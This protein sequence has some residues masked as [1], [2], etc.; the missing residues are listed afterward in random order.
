MVIIVQTNPIKN[1]HAL[2]S[3]LANRNIQFN[4]N[5]NTHSFSLSAFVRLIPSSM[6]SYR[7]TSMSNVEYIYGET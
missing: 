3:T 6:T 7:M 2:T 4:F 1:G 5:N